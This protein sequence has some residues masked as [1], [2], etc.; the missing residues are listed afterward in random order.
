MKKLD[1]EYEEDES[2][3]RQCMHCGRTGN[4]KI[5][6]CNVCGKEMMTKETLQEGVECAICYSVFEQYEDGYRN[7][8]TN[9]LI[10]KDC[11]SSLE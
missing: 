5:D 1:F 9:D 3:K 4:G 10:C 2:L 7:N 8:E 6:K 11:Y